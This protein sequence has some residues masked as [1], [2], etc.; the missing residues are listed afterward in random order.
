MA[1]NRHVLWEN[2][3]VADPV[4]HR[5]KYVK[6]WKILAVVTAAITVA[7]V[8][9]FGVWGLV[10]TVIVLVL[11]GG[12]VEGVYRL[13]LVRKDHLVWTDGALFGVE[14]ASDVIGHPT[15]PI[16]LAQIAQL[17]VYPVAGG[18][19]PS[20]DG[21]SS[22]VYYTAIDLW[23]AG[24]ARRVFIFNRENTVTI[25]EERAL[26]EALRNYLPDR[27]RPAPADDDLPA[28]IGEIERRRL[29]EWAWD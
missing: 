6:R 7:S 15:D 20:Y 13:A 14:G 12:A 16:P 8:L 21:H 24:G 11:G 3:S 17:T 18:Y 29:H 19:L 22:R 5:A 23:L 28:D 27:W 2:K 25:A 10:Y 1:A 26:A 4:A 9:A